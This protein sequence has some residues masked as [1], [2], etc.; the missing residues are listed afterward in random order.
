MV[1]VASEHRDHRCHEAER[2]RA[3]RTR[4][5]SLVKYNQPMVLRVM[6][7]GGGVSPGGAAGMR[8]AKTPPF[9]ELLGQG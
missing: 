2:E 8:A 5:E 3:A 7:G 6:G 1:G 4:V 9:P